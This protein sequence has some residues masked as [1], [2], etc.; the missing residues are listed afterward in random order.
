MKESQGGWEVSYRQCKLAFF[1]FL[2]NT[3]YVRHCK[4]AKNRHL[5]FL[6]PSI[7]SPSGNRTSISPWGIAFLH[8]ALTSISSSYTCDMCLTNQIIA[9]PWQQ[10]LVQG[11]APVLYGP[12]KAASGLDLCPTSWV[13]ELYFSYW[14]WNS[15][16]GSL[17]E[18]IQGNWVMY[19]VREQAR[20]VSSRQRDT[21]HIYQK[22]W[23]EG[24]CSR[25]REWGSRRW[26]QG[27]GQKPVLLGSGVIERDLNFTLRN[28]WKVLGRGIIW[29]VSHFLRTTLSV[30]WHWEWG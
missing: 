14:T 6:L 18:M 23:E 3:S 8:S 2:S 7:T 25:V 11:C 22:K 9:A 24:Q 13:R 16:D 21:P 28:Y 19:E 27:V 20:G 5:L 15:E 29:A 1:F 12:M 4:N 10:C 30:R 26:V 17:G